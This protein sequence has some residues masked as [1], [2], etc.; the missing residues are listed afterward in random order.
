MRIKVIAVI[1]RARVD[2]VCLF[3]T[4][5]EMASDVARAEV[6]HLGL[7]PPRTSSNRH[8][9][10]IALYAPTKGSEKLFF[11]LCFES[12]QTSPRVCYDEDN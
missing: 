5:R 2:D 11:S 12:E 9:D 6:F 1:V 3:R 7:I 4:G 10:S 8:P